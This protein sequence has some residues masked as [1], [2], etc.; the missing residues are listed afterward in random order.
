MIREG[1]THQM[2]SVINTSSREG[3][4]GMDKE[5][6]DL[7]KQGIIEE[8]EAVRAALSPEMMKKKLRS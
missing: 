6:F 8:D 5:I 4:T 2:D 1:K 3:M 7:Y